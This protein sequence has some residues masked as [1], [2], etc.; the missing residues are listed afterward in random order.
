MILAAFWNIA[1]KHEFNMS[2][3]LIISAWYLAWDM[4]LYIFLQGCGSVYCRT[5]EGYETV[6]Y[7]LTKLG[8]LAKP[9][10]AGETFLKGLQTLWGRIVNVKV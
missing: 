8:V 3:S 5:R 4:Y 1:L 9:Y 7:Q 10:H 2:S 6:A